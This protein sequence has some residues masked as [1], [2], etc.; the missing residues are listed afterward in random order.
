MIEY[1]KSKVSLT[2]EGKNINRFIKRL[3]TKKIEILSLKYKDENHVTILVYKKDL[4]TIFKI[5]SIYQ[6]TEN[7]VYGLLK[8]KQNLKLNTHLIIIITISFLIFLF[9]THVIFDIEVIHSSKEIRTLL[10]DELAQYEIKKYSISK[11]FNE[12]EKIKEKI[13]NKYP[14]KL[15]W[16][17]IEREGTKYVVRV[18]ERKITEKDDNNTPRNIIAKK[19]GVLKKVVASK[20]DIV[21]D[22]DDYVNKGDVIV[23]GELIFNNKVTGKVRSEGKAYAEVWY[24]TKT[25]YPFA[26]YEEKETGNTKEIYKIKFL[27]HNLEL[28]FNKY[29]NKKETEKEIIS[30]PLL[31]FKLVKSNQRETKITSEI[32]TFD[33]ALEKAQKLSIKKIK[34]KLQKDEYIIRHKYLKSVVKDSTIEVEMFFAVYEDITDYAEIG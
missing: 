13:L 10:Q 16:L 2:I 3:T 15:E 6:I 1:I 24:V 12:L 11:P 23:N 19:S 33:E 22:M 31:P 4:E 29:K 5:K 17:E 26:Y 32:L 20:G 21:K 34:D 14:D 28:T 7:N 25:E 30:H 27:N 9:F 8:I 18:E